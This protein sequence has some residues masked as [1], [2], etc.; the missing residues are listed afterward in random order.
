MTSIS[1]PKGIQNNTSLQLKQNS[2][3]K[4]GTPLTSKLFGFQN[5]GIRDRIYFSDTEENEVNFGKRP[6]P[7]A[8]QRTRKKDQ[9]LS[10]NN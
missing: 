1:T 7:S 2:T 4:S 3:I 5:N 8:N 6:P 10:Q 9:E